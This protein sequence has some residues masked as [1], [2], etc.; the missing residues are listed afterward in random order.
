MADTQNP[1]ATDIRCGDKIGIPGARGAISLSGRG[2]IKHGF[3]IEVTNASQADDGV[4]VQGYLITQTGRRR[5]G[6]IIRGALLSGRSGDQ[7]SMLARAECP[8]PEPQGILCPP[9][10][11]AVA[12][13]TAAA[14]AHAA[15]GTLFIDGAGNTQI[16]MGDDDDPIHTTRVEASDGA[17]IWQWTCTLRD[18][19]AGDAGFET[20][21]GVFAAALWHGPVESSAPV[22]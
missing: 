12:L 19:S 2:P 14:A 13:I 6:E 8:A 7:W 10:A 5:K 15:G 9:T 1:D 18:C 21:D 4:R 11:D 16:V 3:M 20:E 17:G 22:G